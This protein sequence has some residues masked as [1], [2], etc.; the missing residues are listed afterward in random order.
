MRDTYV[1]RLRA[2]LEA[3]KL[4]HNATT[5]DLVD[6]LVALLIEDAVFAEL[7][8]GTYETSGHPTL[9]K[10]TREHAEQL[11]K[12]ADALGKAGVR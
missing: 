11:R 4:R 1:K 10:T 5:R 6:A 8:A 2:D 7:E 9:A 3:L 12:N